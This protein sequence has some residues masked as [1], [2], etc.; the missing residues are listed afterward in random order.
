MKIHF[1]FKYFAKRIDVELHPS[2][3]TFSINEKD[4]NISFSPFLYLHWDKTMWT[5]I[6]IGEEI[7]IEYHN[8][9][10]IVRIDINDLREN[11]PS[12]SVISSEAFL[13]LLFEYGIGRCFESSLIPQLKPVV[14]IFGADRFN[15]HFKNP[16]TMF[17]LVA[18]RGGAKYV[19]FDTMEL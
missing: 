5:P 14:F 11:L 3:F 4:I 6:A 17:E 1:L 15:E 19:A 10:D 18:K 2:K 9:P 16:K 13:Q 8:N 12:K 7:P